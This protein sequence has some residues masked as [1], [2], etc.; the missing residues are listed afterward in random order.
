MKK[1]TIAMTTLMVLALPAV[2][3]NKIPK[4]IPSVAVD[5]EEIALGERVHITLTI[6]NTTDRAITINETSLVVLPSFASPC[7][8]IDMPIETSG[9]TVAAGDVVTLATDYKPEC[10]RVYSV[11]FYLRFNGSK[12]RT[13]LGTFTVSQPS[14]K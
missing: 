8:G 1:L 7:N 11:Q 6:T 13:A 9:I 10:L 3:Q 12:T 5:R 14:E 4:A 2:A